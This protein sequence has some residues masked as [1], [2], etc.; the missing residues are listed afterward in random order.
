V[1]ENLMNANYTSS[2]GTNTALIESLDGTSK[3]R[4]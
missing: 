3:T 4:F 2:G 1:D